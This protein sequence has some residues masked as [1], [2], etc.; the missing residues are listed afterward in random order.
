MNRKRLIPMLMFLCIAMLPGCRCSHA[1]TTADCTDPERCNLC[2]TYRGDPL[3]HIWIDASCEEPKTCITCGAT[4][5]DP[6]GHSWSEAACTVP[7][8][9]T[10]CNLTEGAASGHHWT[11]AT[12]EAP[13]T[14]TACGAT[15]GEPLPPV[16]PLPDTTCRELVGSWRRS[17]N[18]TTADLG[19]DDY[20]GAFTKH[21]TLTFRD[22]GTLTFSS[23]IE[24]A[25]ALEN[26]IAETL[27]DRYTA[28]G[29]S[30]IEA[31]LALVGDYGKTIPEYAASLAA[32]AIRNNLPPDA[33]GIYFVTDDMLHFAHSR[34]DPATVFSFLIRSG[35][36]TLTNADTG[37]MVEFTRIS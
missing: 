28:R 4:E 37:E 16:S 34:N 3:G 11:P 13:K 10:R 24:N 27:Y 30:R 35:T 19:L 9:C 6:L 29:M 15:E 26:L 32:V 1:W 33:E 17:T 18:I 5:G 8:T 25:E 7:K 12:A 21:I 22:D 20:E 36:L 2:G 23:Q 14:C 31:D